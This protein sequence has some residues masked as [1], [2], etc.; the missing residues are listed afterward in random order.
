[1]SVRPGICNELVNYRRRHGADQTSLSPFLTMTKFNTDKS[2][3]QKRRLS[4]RNE[5]SS[6]R[7]NNASANGFALAL[8]SLAGTVARVA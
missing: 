6:S 2:E 7:P 4:N 1:M 3:L 5:W 8:S